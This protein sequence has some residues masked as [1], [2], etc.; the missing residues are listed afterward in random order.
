MILGKE[1]VI[2]AGDPNESEKTGGGTGLLDNLSD[3]GKNGWLNSAILPI[4][5]GSLVAILLATLL[6]L[7]C[8]WCNGWLCFQ[9]GKEYRTSSVADMDTMQ[10]KQV[11]KEEVKERRLDRREGE[12]TEL[13]DFATVD[14]DGKHLAVVNEEDIQDGLM[15][16]PGN[17][18]LFTVLEEIDPSEMSRHPRRSFRSGPP[19]YGAGHDSERSDGTYSLNVLNLETPVSLDASLRSRY[20]RHRYIHRQFLPLEKK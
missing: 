10:I 7:G 15:I 13:T 1:I 5:L 12:G 19:E 2:E 18:K 3:S 14:R 20:S 16:I 8:C 9:D 11:V 17:R 6:G 4:V